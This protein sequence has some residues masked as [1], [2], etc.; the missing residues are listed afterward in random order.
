VGA[1]I[2]ALVAEKA[3]DYLDAPILRLASPDV[4]IP[5]SPPL[6]Q[7]TLPSVEDIVRAARSLVL[8][9]V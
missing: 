1:E 8:G 2:A 4:P 7:L 6:G 5:V 3:F 9:Q